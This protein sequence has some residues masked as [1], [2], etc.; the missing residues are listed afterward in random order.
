MAQEEHQ[1]LTPRGTWRLV[2]PLK[3]SPGHSGVLPT[4]I[5]DHQPAPKKVEGPI[6]HVAG[7]AGQGAEVVLGREARDEVLGF[8]GG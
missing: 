5:R 2:L 7:A 1:A 3:S 8:R 4:C 6:S